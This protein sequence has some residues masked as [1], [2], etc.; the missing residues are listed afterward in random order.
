VF[1]LPN[2]FFRFELNLDGFDWSQRAWSGNTGP[3]NRGAVVQVVLGQDA[4]V[5]S[6]D[7]TIEILNVKFVPRTTGGSRAQVA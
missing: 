2:R 6:C 7:G 3:V 4:T 5:P 1:C